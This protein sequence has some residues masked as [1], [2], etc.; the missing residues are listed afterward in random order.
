MVR[1]LIPVYRKALQRMMD[2]TPSRL[3]HLGHKTRRHV[4][5]RNLYEM[6]RDGVLDDAIAQHDS[7]EDCPKVTPWQYLPPKTPAGRLQTMAMIRRFMD[8]ASKEFPGGLVLNAKGFKVEKSFVEFIKT[9]REMGSS[10]NDM[11]KAWS[12]LRNMLD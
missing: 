2:E 12:A 3:A 7:G 4:L 8:Q 6:F 11:V 1:D 10:H 5:V 9:H